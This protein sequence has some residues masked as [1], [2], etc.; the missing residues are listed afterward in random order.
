MLQKLALKIT[1]A[2]PDMWRDFEQA[3]SLFDLENNNYQ[4]PTGRFYNKTD[5]SKEDQTECN[6]LKQSDCNVD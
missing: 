4:E 3:V 6:L 1:R 2:T 5:F